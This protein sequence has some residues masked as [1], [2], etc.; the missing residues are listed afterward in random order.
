M[1]RRSNSK[2][3][4]RSA[5]RVLGGPIMRL[6]FVLV[7]VIISGYLA[8]TYAYAPLF[9]DV[10]LPAAVQARNARI[11]TATLDAIAEGMKGRAAHVPHTYDQYRSFFAAPAGD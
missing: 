2:D 4:L 7:C 10:E 8:Y 6:V 1:T 3:M 5:L 11:D 9:D